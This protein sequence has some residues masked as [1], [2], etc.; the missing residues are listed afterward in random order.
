MPS[1]HS[2]AELVVAQDIYPTETTQFADVILP[3]AGWPEKTG[4]MTN[5]DRRRISLLEKAIEPP[6]EAAADS[7][8]LQRFASEMGWSHA[9]AHP[10][11]A[12][13]FAEH[14]ALTK[15]TDIDITG[16]SHIHLKVEGPT[17]WPFPQ[18]KIKNQKSK[19]TTRLYT[20]HL[21]P[22]PTG[23][24]Q[25][26]AITFQDRS[27]QPTPEHPL[28]LTTGRI[29]DQWHTM[30]KTGHVNRLRTHIDS[31]FCE[32]HPIDAAEHKIKDGDMI[33]IANPRGE[34]RVRALVTDTI[35]PGVLFLPMH[36]GK[37][38]T[39]D[40]AAR[41]RANNLTSP[42]LDPISKEPDLKLAIAQAAEFTPPKRAS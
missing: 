42:R 7:E 9:F 38:L 34:V 4:T 31:P 33:T 20:N 11:A 1:G 30:T 8:I 13:V 14:A 15:G 35:R 10:N 17:Q 6:G 32:I 24:A 26:A 5:S 40:P 39:G 29:R 41:G 23:R 25:L 37:R 18:S 3:A 28:I 36:W 21:F 19:I 27:E 22:T 12:A 2:P 16:I